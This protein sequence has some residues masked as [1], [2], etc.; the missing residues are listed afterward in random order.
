MTKCYSPRNVISSSV[1]T[2]SSRTAAMIAE[3]LNYFLSKI[4]HDLGDAF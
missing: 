1:A 4:K 3:C 2:L